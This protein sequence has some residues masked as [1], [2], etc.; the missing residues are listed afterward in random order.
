VKVYTRTGDKGTTALLGGGRVQKSH[1]RVDAYGTVDELNAVLGWALTQLPD[2][3]VKL[4]LSL[5]QHDLFVIGAELA[6][7]PP[8]PGRVRP[9]VPELPRGRASEMEAWIDEAETELEPLR[10]FIL[11]GGT[12]GASALHVART[13]CRRAERGAVGL[14]E[15]DSVDPDVVLYLN[16]LSDLLFVFAR[17]ANARAGVADVAW[18]KEADPGPSAS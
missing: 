1:P 16:R 14:S 5:L 9:S 3:S 17:L 8:A 2:D 6:A 7:P 10:V 12:P 11:P 15:N 13:V 18:A 4:R